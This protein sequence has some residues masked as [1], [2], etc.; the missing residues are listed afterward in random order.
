MRASAEGGDGG[1][2]S[3]S[4]AGTRK[5]RAPAGR[6]SG[7]G[8]GAVAPMREET[9]ESSSSFASAPSTSTSDTSTS[10]QYGRKKQE[11][12]IDERVSARILKRII[13]F[14][15]VPLAVGFTGFPALLLYMRIA[16]G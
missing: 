14:S 12:G 11:E 8:F 15:G 7:K 4:G 3:T 5:G 13:I 16:N 9:P 2:E 1:E 10:S 6:K